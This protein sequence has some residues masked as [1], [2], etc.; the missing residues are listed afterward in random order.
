[1]LRR[2]RILA[3]DQVERSIQVF[4][5]IGD[6]FDADTE[7]HQAV[8]GSDLLPFLPGNRCVGHGGRVIDQALDVAE[9]LGQREDLQA[10]NEV[11]GLLEIGVELKGDDP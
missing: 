5:Q 6:R 3:L 4:D 9:A 1:M 8:L 7:S 10:P 2:L 11:L